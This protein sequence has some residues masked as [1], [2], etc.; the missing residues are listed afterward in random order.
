MKQRVRGNWADY[1]R[2]RISDFGFEH[3][4]SRANDLDFFP[5]KFTRFAGVRI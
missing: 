4:N 3:S 1:L 2:F 5:P